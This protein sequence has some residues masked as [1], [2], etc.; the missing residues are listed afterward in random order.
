MAYQLTEILSRCDKN[1]IDFFI[2]TIDSYVN[3]SDDKG[4]KE[5][6]KMWDDKNQ[7]LPIVLANKIE[8][9][10]R[11]VGSNDAAYAYRKIKGE[12]PAGVK[13]EEMINDVCD[14]MKIKVKKIGTIESKLEMLCRAIVDKEIFS[15]NKEKQKELLKS[16]NISDETV[17]VIINQLDNK[18]KMAIPILLAV[19]GKQTSIQIVQGIISAVIS[20]FIGKQAAKTLIMN[21]STKMPW[22]AALGPVFIGIVTGWTI[23]DFAGPATRKTIPLLLYLGLICLRDGETKD[24]WGDEEKPDFTIEYK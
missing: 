9:E 22:L 18:K 11:Y 13:I 5:L 14:A 6:N 16:M 23:I 8:T 21:L 4:L 19:L 10:I 2:N 12:V 1:D 15:L 3:F 20:T 24:F 17:K 7:K